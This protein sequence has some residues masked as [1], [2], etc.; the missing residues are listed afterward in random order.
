MLAN[1]GGASETG[2]GSESAQERFE[3]LSQSGQIRVS[4]A[5]MEW[6]RMRIAPV[7]PLPKG[8]NSRF[9]PRKRGIGAISCDMSN[10]RVMIET[11]HRLLRPF[12]ESC[13]S[14][15]KKRPR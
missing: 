6:I 15:G 1:R 12:R 9:P 4:L 8:G 2:A 5:T 3:K 11:I 13:P 10:N 14:K 7:P